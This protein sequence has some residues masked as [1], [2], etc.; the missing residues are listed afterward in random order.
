VLV[1]KDRTLPKLSSL[2]EADRRTLDAMCDAVVN[3]LL[4]APLTELKRSSRDGDEAATIEVT[5]R[6]FQLEIPE[7]DGTGGDDEEDDN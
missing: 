1:E 7:S 4:H 3:K 2:N 5:Q 6:L